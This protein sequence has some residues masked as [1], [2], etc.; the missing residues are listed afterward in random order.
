MMPSNHLILYHPPDI[1]KCLLE[2]KPALNWEMYTYIHKTIIT[3][4]SVKTIP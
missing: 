1:D 3:L 2:S 4:Q